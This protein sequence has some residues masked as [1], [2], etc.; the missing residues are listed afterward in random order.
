[1]MH[2]NIHATYSIL[3][4]GCCKGFRLHV[5]SMASV[6]RA[7]PAR[8]NGFQAPE[9]QPLIRQG[10]A[11]DD[12]GLD[13]MAGKLPEPHCQNI[14]EMTLRKF[15]R[16]SNSMRFI[17]SIDIG[18]KILVLVTLCFMLTL[19]QAGSASTVTVQDANV[20][21][22]GGTANVE[23]RLDSAPAGLSGYNITFSLSNP[24][25]AEITQVTFPSWA[26][27][28]QTSTFPSDQVWLKA[29]DLGN[30]APRLKHSSRDPDHPG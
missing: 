29:G 28:T 16:R 15:G 17:R 21:A 7:E 23:I 2:L 30:T 13:A 8:A 22:I 4:S 9:F 18:K 26:V 10:M 24:G 11:G 3:D 27:I 1:M 12:C 14:A 25:I 20:P 5:P 6:V 19:V